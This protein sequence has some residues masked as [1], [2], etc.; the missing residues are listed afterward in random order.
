MQMFGASETPVVLVF[1]IAYFNGYEES[2][3]RDLV[4]LMFLNS[5]V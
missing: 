5:S 1:G 4:V 3:V 2:V